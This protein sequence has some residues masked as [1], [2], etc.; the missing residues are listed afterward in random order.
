MASQNI[1]NFFD[2]NTPETGDTPLAKQDFKEFENLNGYYL[3][4]NY[5]NEELSII[6]Y[7]IDSLEGIRYETNLQL[8]EL[9][10]ISR[11]FKKLGN[12]EEI[13]KTIIELINQ[14]KYKIIQKGK[15]LKFLLMLDA[16]QN[17]GN[18][19]VFNLPINNE[20]NKNEYIKL[21]SDSIKNLRIKNNEY[22]KEKEEMLD[23]FKRQNS[24]NSFNSINTIS[25]NNK[26]G[27][28]TLTPRTFNLNC[29]QCYLIPQIYLK[30][31]NFPYIQSKCPNNHIEKKI[32]L[33]DFVEKGQKFSKDSL[34]C[35]CKEFS[36][37]S[38]LALYYCKNCKTILCE[39]CNSKHNSKHKIIFEELM[40][41]YCLIHQLE[42]SAYCND[43]DT[44]ICQDCINDHKGHFL[45][46]FKNIIPSKEEFNEIK[47]KKDKIIS[48]IDNINQILD[49]YKKEF[50]DKIKKIKKYFI[51]EKNIIEEIIHLY[52][53]EIYNY[54][55]IKNLG[56]IIDFNFEEININK[57]DSFSEKTKKIL[58][59]F[60]SFD[61]QTEQN[62]NIKLVKNVKNDETIYSLC[63]LKKHNLIAMG[64]DKKINLVDFEFNIIT[65]QIL[66]D[67]IAYI[68]ELNDGKIVAVDLN[69]FVKILQIKEGK[70]EIFKT[71]ETKEERNFVVEELSNKNIICGG[72]QYLS[73]IEIS[74]FF[75]YSLKKALEL[76][77]F[78]SNIVEIDEKSFLVGLSHEH[79]II[80]YSSNDYHEIT[81]INNI[82]LRGN[83]YSI[84]KISNELIGIAGYDRTPN[85]KACI[86]IFS[87]ENK[88]ICKKYYLNDIE[89]CM[90]IVKFSKDEFISAGTSL[91]IDNHTDLILLSHKNESK[92]LNVEEKCHFKRGYCDTIEAI[93]TFKNNIIAS[94]SSSNLKVWSIE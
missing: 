68:K 75:G 85:K 80:I 13:Y 44:N 24:I 9:F 70:L 43:C 27:E 82:Y 74:F 53:K 38:N 62:K 41:Y 42:F 30:H 56:N 58:K 86:Y 81:K 1:I 67:K 15:S 6:I 60:D 59:I 69:K 89:S 66:D 83:N 37:N 36:N 4:V 48:N 34:K 33:L 32:S 31:S 47:K 26:E 78:I 7:N 94:D 50:L 11:V 55:V 40:N 18:E 5:I 25:T 39:K 17:E 92:Q 73:I 57:N 72:D 65:S 28:E 63:Y 93:I 91:D 22:F 45:E 49:S 87:K 21:L 10:Q 54:Q 12:I 16:S 61:V 20:D 29:S 14:N 3:K 77:T 23:I 84:S 51:H 90:I 76:N 64:L 71:I 52:S 35:N 8:K 46:E 2:Q 19:I 88:N 79:K